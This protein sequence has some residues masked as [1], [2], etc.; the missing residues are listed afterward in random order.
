MYNRNMAS[1]IANGI[2]LPLGKEFKQD[3]FKSMCGKT[4]VDEYDNFVRWDKIKRIG[5]DIEFQR[6]VS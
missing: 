5:E 1:E 2:C 4:W 3:R 6:M